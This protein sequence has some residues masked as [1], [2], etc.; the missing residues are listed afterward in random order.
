MLKF[1]P[2]SAASAILLALALGYSSGA[3]AQD[4]GNLPAAPSAVGR[5]VVAPIPGAAGSSKLVT[6]VQLAQVGG[7]GIVW[8]MPSGNDTTGDGSYSNPFATP[9]VAQTYVQPGGSLGCG[10]TLT[11]NDLVISQS[12]ETLTPEPGVGC[13]L[14]VATGVGATKGVELTAAGSQGFTSNVQVSTA[15]TSAAAYYQDAGAAAPL[16]TLNSIVTG[17]TGANV[18]NADGAVCNYVFGVAFAATG[19]GMN[20][21]LDQCS[22]VNVSGGMNVQ[23]TPV[24]TPSNVDNTAAEPA[25]DMI[26]N[27]G[28]G[29]TASNG[30]VNLTVKI[31]DTIAS[32]LST[33]STFIPLAIY[34]ATGQVSGLITMNSQPS[35]V[36]SLCKIAQT[37]PDLIN[38]LFP[39]VGVQFGS[40][41]GNTSYSQGNCHLATWAGPNLGYEGYPAVGTFTGTLTGPSTTL[42]VTNWTPTYTG[43]LLLP[44]E[45]IDG[46]PGSTLLCATP[47]PPTCGAGAGTTWQTGGVANQPFWICAQTSGTTGGNGHY[48]VTSGAKANCPI[49]GGSGAVNVAQSLTPPASGP[50]SP[51]T[52]AGPAYS[53]CLQAGAFSDTSRISNWI[54]TF[55]AI[56]LGYASAVTEGL[57]ALFATNFTVDHVYVAQ[58]EYCL[59]FKGDLIGLV[60]SAVC[61]DIGANAAALGHHLDTRGNSAIVY[62]NITMFHGAGV[63]TTI[64]GSCIQFEPYTTSDFPAM[65]YEGWTGSAVTGSG[66]DIFINDLCDLEEG[67]GTY[68]FVSNSNPCDTGVAYCY[69]TAGQTSAVWYTN[70]WFAHFGIPTGGYM[71]AL[72]VAA[73]SQQYG[74]SFLCWTTGAAN[75]TH[76]TSGATAI[77]PTDIN[78]NPFLTFT[79]PGLTVTAP[80]SIAASPFVTAN[81]RP[82]LGSALVGAGHAPIASASGA[83]VTTDAYGATIPAAAPTIGAAMF[84]GALGTRPAFSGTLAQLNIFNPDPQIGD[85]ATITGVSTCTNG[86]APSGSGSIACHVIYIGGAWV[87]D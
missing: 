41:A 22:G 68:K 78:A 23:L 21:D 1:R 9:A 2:F 69:S 20:L 49:F 39:A 62:E 28:P 79:G 70:G 59:N 19:G 71:F 84:A 64:A 37:G 32:A 76:P 54:G 82:L 4:A 58:G 53:G 14:Q 61:G 38:P 55:G 29:A 63:S 3:A 12:G 42:T 74:N 50:C 72:D 52:S 26:D 65:P 34:N 56:P 24:G 81:V 77:A 48:T 85:A 16:I 35:D 80:A 75:C 45:R 10:G 47:G 36:H 15:G 27:N 13:I 5:A 73:G 6:A 60:Y 40:L 66:P 18:A 44:G 7:G 51:S 8:A 87:A 33:G 25:L 43:G 83:A 86:V 46:G 11:I 31:N 57:G 30:V 17:G 67:T